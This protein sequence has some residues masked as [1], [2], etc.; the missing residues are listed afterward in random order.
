[1]SDSGYRKIII[2]FP[3]P[4]LINFLKRLIKLKNGWASIEKNG[5][6]T[7]AFFYDEGGCIKAD[8]TWKVE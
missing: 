3:K 5:W 4:G 2:H 6:V 8:I 1:M 7:N